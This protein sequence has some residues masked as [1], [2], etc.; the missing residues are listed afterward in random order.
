MSDLT[1]LTL[2]E[3]IQALRRGEVSSREL[4]QA[5]L[6]Q[7]ERLDPLIKAFIT[8]APEDALEK[9]SQ[10]D[11][12]WAE[13]RRDRSLSLPALLGTPVAIKDVLCVKG[14]PCTCGS[15]ILE[16]YRPPYTAT[17]VERL[18]SAGM[19]IVGKTNL[20]EM[21][22]MPVTGIP[23]PFVSYGGSSLVLFWFLTGLIVNVRHNWQEY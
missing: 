1:D 9:A 2:L 3:S 16:N 10:A 22:L 11:Q 4:V 14:L 13:W 19:I 18:L 7:I 20:P 12:Q 17:A 21:G 8:L 23:L 5:S 15:R 6:D